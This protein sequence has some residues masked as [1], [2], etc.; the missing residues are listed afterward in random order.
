MDKTNSELNS[1]PKV[2]TVIV[3]A[4]NVSEYIDRCVGSVMSAPSASLVET[5]IVNDG[6]KDDTGSKAASLAGTFGENVVVIDKENG[7]HG[8]TINAGLRAAHGKYVRILDGDDFVNTDDFERL[9]GILCRESADVVL[10]DY[11]EYHAEDGATVPRRYYEKMESGVVYDFDELCRGETAFPE[12]GPILATAAFRLEVLKDR[13]TLTERSYYIDMEFDAY[14]VEAVKSAVYYPLD[15][16]RYYIGRADQSINQNSYVRN[17]KQHENVLFKLIEYYYG[18][19]MTEPKRNYILKKLVIPMVT[20]QYV[21]LINYMKSGK[22]YRAFE[23][24]LS[25]YPEIANHPAVA[26]KMKRFHR[27]T[28][29]IFVK[30]DSLIKKA[31]GRGNG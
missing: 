9:V 27:A 13:F 3:P 30:H 14:S 20:A 12:W 6:S 1:G 10:T 26:T 29:G 17:F 11:S 2:L 22:E 23:K 18:G 31:A 15:V 16:Y 7:G 28:R 25:A 19:A 8:S 21:I 4:Y 24:R 5:V